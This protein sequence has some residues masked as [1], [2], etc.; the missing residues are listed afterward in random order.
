MATIQL[1]SGTWPSGPDQRG[2][3]MRTFL[4]SAVAL[5]I[6]AS[7]SALADNKPHGG[8]GGTPSPKGAHMG[9][10]PPKAAVHVQ[11]ARPGMA[12]HATPAHRARVSKHRGHHHVRPSKRRHVT[13]RRAPPVAVHVDVTSKLHRVFRAPRRFHAGLYN[14]PYGWYSYDWRVGQRLP[15]AWFVREYWIGDWGM[16]GLFAPPAGMMWVR[17]GPDAL[18]IDGGSG[19]VVDVYSDLFW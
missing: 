18:L 15:R 8:S 10:K 6:A 1:W 2:I 9:A 17:V 4:V 13:V 11:P 5:M 7:S 12:H 16:Y 3:S 14:R 19:E